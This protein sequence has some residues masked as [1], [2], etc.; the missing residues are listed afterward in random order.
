M[1]PEILRAPIDYLFVDN[2]YCNRMYHHPTRKKA[3]EE[4]RSR[5]AP[6][7]A[8]HVRCSAAF[9]PPPSAPLLCS[10]FCVPPSHAPCITPLPSADSEQPSSSQR[11]PPM[12]LAKLRAADTVSRLSPA[13]LRSLTVTT[14]PRGGGCFL[15]RNF[16]FV[17][18]SPEAFS[19]TEISPLN[20]SKI[21]PSINSP[22]LNS[23]TANLPAEP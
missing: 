13:W 2:T 19:T 7:F 15:K 4:V 1:P 5:P 3:T 16:H 8:V 12:R 23:P 20:H 21:Q 17:L 18:D 11:R 22:L 6:A 10:Q 9:P 14:E